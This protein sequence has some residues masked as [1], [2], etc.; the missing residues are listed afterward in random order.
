MEQC[1]GRLRVKGKGRQGDLKSKPCTVMCHLC[2]PSQAVDVAKERIYLVKTEA[3]L[4][5]DDL[6]TVVPDGSPRYH[7]FIF[8]H[9][10]EG[11]YQESV[12]RLWDRGVV[13]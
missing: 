10:F 9:T 2:L 3:S 5:A 4:T 8:K 6:P 13:L 1:K 11:D 12:G 7:F